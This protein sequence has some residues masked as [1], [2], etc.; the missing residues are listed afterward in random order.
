MGLR[1]VKEFCSPKWGL[2]RRCTGISAECLPEFTDVLLTPYHW[3]LTW[4]ELSLCFDP[5]DDL[6]G[7]SGGGE[8]CGATAVEILAF[9]RLSSPWTYVRTH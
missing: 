8:G 3:L 6:R 7:A 4:K 2:R 5:V 1:K 9:P